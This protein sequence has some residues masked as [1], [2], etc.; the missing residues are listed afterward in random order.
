[1][2]IALPADAESAIN[3]VGGIAALLDKNGWKAAAFIACAVKMPGRTGRPKKSQDAAS[4]RLTTRDFAKA[5]NAKGWSHFVIE[6][7]FQG[8]EDAAEAGV[9]PH[10]E[11]LVYGEKIDIPT[12][13]WAEFYPPSIE[14]DNRYTGVEDK[15]A[16]LAEA[17][18]QGLTGS[19]AVDI[20][21]NLKSLGTAMKASPKV[22][23]AAAAFLAGTE[24]AMQVAATVMAVPEDAEVIIGN[25]NV[26]ESVVEAQANHLRGQRKAHTPTTRLEKP[27]V[28]ATVGGTLTLGTLL[29]DIRR[30]MNGLAFYVNDGNLDA[31]WL[32]IIRVFLTDELILQAQGLLDSPAMTGVDI[33]PEAFGA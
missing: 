32:D 21:K 3:E 16:I 12:E 30:D 25:P 9:V 22:R 19:K 28:S 18:A 23:E 13:G 27:P 15:E 7:H 31:D 11:N 26:Y 33:T 8:W 2:R 6:R 20:A 24:E 5:I 17:A 10:A 14:S 29:D 1:M 4:S